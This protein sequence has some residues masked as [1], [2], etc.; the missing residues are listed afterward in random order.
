[1]VICFVYI[2]LI[3]LNT[4]SSVNGFISAISAFA[5]RA[6]KEI[7]AAQALPLAQKALQN[8]VE[9]RAFDFR[10]LAHLFLMD[11]GM[12]GNNNVSG[13]EA[14]LKWAH[15]NI[16]DFAHKVLVFMAKG[17]CA[18][19]CDMIPEGEHPHQL[20]VLHDV[21]NLA[22]NLV[23]SLEHGYNE[24]IT[25]C[26]ERH[27]RSEWLNGKSLDIISTQNLNILARNKEAAAIEKKKK[28]RIKKDAER[29][30]WIAMNSFGN[31]DAGNPSG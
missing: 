14:A 3:G 25:A 7:Q 11:S 12:S 30:S 23:I 13:Q 31:S 20:K 2:V 5:G 26:V 1:M 16:D 27:M 10:R 24:Q 8:C 15:D 9:L 4:D 17:L 28:E 21:L 18:K 6:G 22:N 19:V 29:S